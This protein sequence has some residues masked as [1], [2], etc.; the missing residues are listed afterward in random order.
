MSVFEAWVDES[1]SNQRV[2]PGTYILS[3]V[4]SEAAKAAAVREAMRSLLVGKRHRKLHWRDEDRGRQHAIATTIA[5][6]DVEHVV[7][8][9]SRPD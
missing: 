7:V 8:V 2:D 1:G 6:L 5:R 9:R 3:A 4:I